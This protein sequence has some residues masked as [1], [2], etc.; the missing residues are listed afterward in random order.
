[1]PATGDV[2]WSRTTWIAYGVVLALV[3]GFIFWSYV[4]T[5]VFGLFVYYATRP[6]HRRIRRH[7]RQRTVAA[8]LSLLT[9]AVPVVLLIAYTTAIAL[10]EIGRFSTTAD[11]GPVA[12]VL[13]P[14]IDVSA[15]VDDPTTLLENAGG[16]ETIRNTLDQTLN[17]LGLV[18][19][20]LIH[21]FL[22]FAVAFYLLR[23]GHRVERLAA[24]ASDDHDVLDAYL[25]AVDRSL[26]KI[27]FG[28][29]LNA[30]MTAAIGAISFSLLNVVAPDAFAIPYPALMGVLAGVASLI[31]IVGMKLVWVPLAGFLAFRA[32]VTGAGW[33]FV[34]LFSLVSIVVVDAIPDFALRP[35]VSGRSLHVGSVMIA[36]IVGPLLFGWPGIF[37]GPML[38]VVVTQFVRIVLPELLSGEEIRPDA[39]DLSVVEGAETETSAET[40]PA[41]AV[42]EDVEEVP[43]GSGP[44]APSVDPGEG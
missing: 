22:M 5:V 3:L 25:R 43:G 24:L 44:D 28:N 16:V 10:Q 15:V 29:L 11:L 8:T 21:A 27:F 6:F 32:S 4:G 20:T 39:V 14:Y 30:V 41:D 35:Y 26:S 38:L 31:P 33:G 18:G 2:N 40:P 1:M 9:L 37:L 23:D 17:Y 7:V 13:Q 34:G 42:E 19:T 12:D 36:Y